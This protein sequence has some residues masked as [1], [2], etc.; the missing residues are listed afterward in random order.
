MEIIITDTRLAVVDALQKMFSNF[1][2]P[3]S[4]RVTIRVEHGD[5]CVWDARN[6]C[7]VNAGN[8]VG[9]MSG[10]LDTVLLGLVPGAEKD[11]LR[12]LSVHGDVSRGGVRHFPLFSAL[13]SP[14]TNGRWLLT[15]PCMYVGGPLDLRGTRNAFHATHTALSHLYQAL[16]SGVV[17]DRV[18]MTGTC[19]GHGRMNRDVMAKQMFE[20]FRSVLV[21][22][23]MVFDPTQAAHPRLMLNRQYTVQPVFD[24]HADFQPRNRI[25]VDSRGQHSHRGVSAQDF[26]PAVVRSGGSEE[27]SPFVNANVIK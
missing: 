24:V 13:M 21:N 12:A 6:T 8:C 27:K 5:V 17:L 9:D 3:A 18:V 25:E 19:S 26:N 7:F 23:N 2:I 15:A 16:R 10:K 1:Q 20:A 11:V 4:R 14:G 22:D